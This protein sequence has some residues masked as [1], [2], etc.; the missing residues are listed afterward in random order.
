MSRFKIYDPPTRG[1][2]SAGQAVG[3]RPG[4]ALNAA[5]IVVCRL[6]S[7]RLPGK[8][9]RKV[10][11]RPL[12]QWVVE[13]ARRVSGFDR[14]LIVATSD[15]KVDDPILDFCL[16]NNLP[17]FRGSAQDVAGRIRDCAREYEL[18]WFARVNADSPFVEPKLLDQACI[19]A[20]TGLYDLVTNLSPRSYPYGVSAE[21]I[22]R[23]SFEVACRKMATAADREHVTR[24][25]YQQPNRLEY[26]KYNIL[27]SEGDLSQVRL[28]VDTPEDWQLFCRIAES[29]EGDLSYRSAIQLLQPSREAA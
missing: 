9:L 1:P 8:V 21:L 14:G 19:Q 11:D 3:G 17:C 18:D 13:R 29:E 23:S 28:T 25:Y 26:R 10:R 22:R 5:G 6:D 24:I 2:K 7:T 27:H 15:R 12:L 16:S 20:K 4:D